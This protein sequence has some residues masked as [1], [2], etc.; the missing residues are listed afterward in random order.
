MARLKRRNYT[1]IT[2]FPGQKATRE[3]LERLLNRYRFAQGFAKDKDVLEVGFGSGLGMEYLSRY[4]RRVAGCDI[5][6]QNVSRAAQCYGEVERIE[7]ILCADAHSLPFE[8]DSFDLVVSFETIYYLEKPEVFVSEA[9][10]VLREKGTLLIGTANKDWR[11]FHPSRYSV[12]YFSVPE[13]YR[14]MRTFFQEVEI[15]GAFAVED[16]GVRGSFL[17]F[18]KRAASRARLIPGSLKAREFL[19]RLFIGELYPIPE[20]ISDEMADYREPIPIDPTSAHHEF[21]II[22]AIAR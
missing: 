1:E 4:A 21:K 3:Q 12:R 11:D 22:Y 18:L 6:T 13:L 16:G 5:D 20:R 19:K 7:K 8:D 14:L 17:S 10:R 15:R 2:E 9:K